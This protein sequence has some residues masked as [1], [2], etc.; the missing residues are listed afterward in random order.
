M[1]RQNPSGERRSDQLTP[2]SP[3][4]DP[5]RRAPAS[6]G[7]GEE[8]KRRV[9]AQLALPAPK[10]VHVQ[11]LRGQLDGERSPLAPRIPLTLL[12]PLT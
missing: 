3:A 4:Q 10:W 8:T 2:V 6:R 9:L 11:A 12:S 7:G 5:Q 1:A